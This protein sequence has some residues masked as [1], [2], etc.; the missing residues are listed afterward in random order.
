MR[1]ETGELIRTGLEQG[2]TSNRGHQNSCSKSRAFFFS[3]RL[4]T[5]QGISCSKKSVFRNYSRLHLLRVRLSGLSKF[6]ICSNL[7]ACIERCY[8]SFF[9]T[10][11]AIFLKAYMDTT[12]DRRAESAIVHSSLEQEFT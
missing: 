10:E 8:D 1:Y 11:K 4:L 12:R 6:R 7:F 2:L 3:S 9:C 5:I